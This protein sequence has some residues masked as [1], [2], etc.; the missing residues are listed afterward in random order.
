MII[1]F[2]Y[3]LVLLNHILYKYIYDL[4]H[5]SLITPKIIKGYI[6]NHIDEVYYGHFWVEYNNKT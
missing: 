3:H 5:K 1:K 4:T 2:T 6:V